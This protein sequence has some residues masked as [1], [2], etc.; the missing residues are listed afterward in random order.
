MT[1]IINWFTTN[2]WGL[3]A[4]VVGLIVL[5]LLIAF[6]LEHRTRRLYPDRNRRGTKAANAAKKKKKAAQAK[7]KDSED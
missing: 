5:F 7:V 1:E 4:L 6:M 2:L 3:G